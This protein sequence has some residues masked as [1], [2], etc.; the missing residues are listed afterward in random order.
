MTRAAIDEKLPANLLSSPRDG[1][2]EDRGANPI[3]LWSDAFKPFQMISNPL[4]RSFPVRDC[5]VGL[6][7][8]KDVESSSF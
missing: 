4:G 7:R 6:P 1:H 5:L 2:V 8:A 3:G